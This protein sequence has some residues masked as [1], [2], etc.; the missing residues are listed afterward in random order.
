[1]FV[2][3]VKPEPGLH[4]TNYLKLSLQAFEKCIVA[5]CVKCSR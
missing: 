2:Q 4:H 5:Y 1:M 3:V